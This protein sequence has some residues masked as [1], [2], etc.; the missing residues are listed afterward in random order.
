M[1]FDPVADITDMCC[2]SGSLK[3]MHF[4]RTAIFQKRK[5]GYGPSLTA[6]SVCYGDEDLRQRKDYPL[7]KVQFYI[8]LKQDRFGP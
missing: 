3:T 7:V 2:C 1:V 8:F 5:G 4:R 6:L